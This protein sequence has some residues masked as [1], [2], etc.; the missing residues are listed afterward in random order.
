[1]RDRRTAGLSDPSPPAVEPDDH[2]IAI[3]NHRNLA[4][5]AGTGQH[6]R[7]VF[8]A[9]Q[10]VDKFA[11]N[12]TLGVGLTGRPG[13]RSGHFTEYVDFLRHDRHLRRITRFI[14]SF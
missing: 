4:L 13:E 3:D 14:K 2:L 11:L 9:G 7:Q 6:L 10:H 8:G 5:T 1:M 12:P